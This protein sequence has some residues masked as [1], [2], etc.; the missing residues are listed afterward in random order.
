MT[1]MQKF[2]MSL[3]AVE[4]GKPETEMEEFF[5]A[6]DSAAG[7]AMRKIA[8][9]DAEKKRMLDQIEERIQQ[10]TAAM[11][12]KANEVKR[13]A[14]NEREYFE[15]LLAV[16]FANLPA[17]SIK[18]TKAGR[19]SYDLPEGKLI[20]T[21]PKREYLHDDARLL[22]VLKNNDMGEYIRRKETPDWAAIKKTIRV[23]E[24]GNVAMVNLMGEIIETDAISVVEV[25]GEFRVEVE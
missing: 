15:R 19:A 8:K 24:A 5:L 7:W 25:P 20:I 6:D 16:Y 17:S 9:I 12:F 3:D 21:A 10:F 23:D 1:E 11:E 18:K 13:K 14:D 2:E 22:D 4:F